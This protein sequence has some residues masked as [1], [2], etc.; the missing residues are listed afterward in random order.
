MGQRYQAVPGG[1][2]VVST[3]FNKQKFGVAA[4]MI[5]LAFGLI[6]EF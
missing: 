1:V 5:A 2:Q 3:V 4:T 6:L